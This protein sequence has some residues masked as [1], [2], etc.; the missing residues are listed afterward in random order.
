MLALAQ[1]GSVGGLRP[2]VS[3]EEDVHAG[4][5][6]PVEL[7]RGGGLILAEKHRLVQAGST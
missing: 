7:G 3:G 5:R 2:P 6:L 4:V 1:A